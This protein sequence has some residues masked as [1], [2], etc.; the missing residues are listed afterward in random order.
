MTHSFHAND[1][2]KLIFAGKAYL[3]K[4]LLVKTSLHKNMVVLFLLAIYKLINREYVSQSEG[5]ICVE[6]V[7]RKVVLDRAWLITIQPIL[8]QTLETNFLFDFLKDRAPKFFRI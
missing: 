6:L 7:V 8:N 2:G 3:K 1:I 5:G 4:T